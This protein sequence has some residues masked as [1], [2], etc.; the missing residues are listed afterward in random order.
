MCWSSLS[1]PCLSSM[2]SD[3]DV[4]TSQFLATTWSLPVSWGPAGRQDT[5]APEACCG[6]FQSLLPAPTAL[7][8][9]P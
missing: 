8:P 3:C 1:S 5:L 2:G 9:R 6:A 4:T 7:L